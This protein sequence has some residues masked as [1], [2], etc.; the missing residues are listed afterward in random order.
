MADIP[1]GE[2]AGVLFTE[3]IAHHNAEVKPDT[4]GFIPPLGTGTRAGD[5]SETGATRQAA[6]SPHGTG[7]NPNERSR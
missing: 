2:D 6:D 7:T 5:D 1:T 4:I 3:S